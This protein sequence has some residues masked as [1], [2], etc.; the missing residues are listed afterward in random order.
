MI[1]VSLFKEIML[2]KSLFKEIMDARTII[3]HA[4]GTQAAILNPR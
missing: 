1:E 2:Y 3:D 4:V